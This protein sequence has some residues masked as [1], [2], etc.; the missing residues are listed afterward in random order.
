MKPGSTAEGQEVNR[1]KAGEVNADHAH[2]S[3]T[4]SENE[5]APTPISGPCLVTTRRVGR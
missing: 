4:L 5:Q 2:S 1:L 3:C